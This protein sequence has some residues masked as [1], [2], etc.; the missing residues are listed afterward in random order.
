MPDVGELQEAIEGLRRD[1]HQLA[2]LTHHYEVSSGYLLVQGADG[3]RVIDMGQLV[4]VQAREGR[5]HF[6]LA[7]GRE[8][9]GNT[10]YT[11]DKA[12]AQLADYPNVVRTRDDY[13]VNLAYVRGIGPAPKGK[14]LYM[15]A[16]P[17][18]LPLASRFERTLE[19][20]FGLTMLV[21]AVPWND[22]YQALIDEDIRDFEQDLRLMPVDDLKLEFKY[23]TTDQVNV[24]ELMAN[25]I[26][27]YR[28][29]LDLPEG[30]PRRKVPVDGNIRTFWY[31]LKPIL[32]RLGILDPDHQYQTMLD[33]FNRCVATDR[34]YHY[35]DFG[36]ADENAGRRQVGDKYPHIILVAEKDGHYS[37]LQKF[38]EEFGLSIIA[39]G[40]QPSLL[41]VEFFYT[42]LAKVVDFK[43]TPLRLIAL[44]DYDFSG[45]III[46][47]FHDRLRDFGVKH[48]T[49]ADVVRPERFT[50]EELPGVIY[51]LPLN[52]KG[53]L[54]KAK[55]WVAGG[56]GID[57]QLMGIESEALIFTGRLHDTVA[58]LFE[59]AKQPPPPEALQV[60]GSALARWGL[61]PAFS[62]ELLA[63]DEEG[64]WV[65]W[66]E[67]ARF[68]ASKIG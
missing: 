10:T 14:L 59:E 44:V 49:R 29:W 51:N 11:L 30:D 25:V 46:S 6:V 15:S 38:Q 63:P 45:D 54:T 40:G 28:C 22:R 42:E 5:I 65:S 37:R 36:F 26:W 35:R 24:R 62:A 13:L 64:F 53:D 2:R 48:Q 68:P 60:D 47:A 58:K 67:T 7:D 39:L 16:G 9:A 20:F 12:V 4:Y 32:S 33:V 66:A 1:R 23:Q 52:T 27:Q 61:P 17:A 18:T 50:P 55:A 41:T 3:G 57:G 19:H 8:V 21:H 43:T 31:Y 56:G 34:L